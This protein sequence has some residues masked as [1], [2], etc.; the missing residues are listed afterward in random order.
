MR[1]MSF[2]VT[3]VVAASALGAQQQA[4]VFRAKT[5]LLQLD[6]TV[7]DKKGVPVRGLTKDDFTLLEDNKPQTIQGFTAVDLPDRKIGGPAWGDRVASDVTSNEIENARIFVLVIDDGLS[8]GVSGPPPGTPDGGAIAL[9]KDGAEA[10]LKSLGPLDLAAVLFTQRTSF[11]QSLTADKAK[12]MAAIRAFPSAGGGDLLPKYMLNPKTGQGLVIVPGTECL[13]RVHALGAMEGLMKVLS[14]LPDRRKAIVYFGGMLP[15][16]H[17]PDTCTVYQRWRDLF[18]LAQQTNVTINPVDTMGLRAGGTVGPW[19]TYGAAAENTG[20]RAVFGSNDLKP[21]LERI[22][23]ENSSYYLLAYS[24]TKGLEDGTFRRLTVKV[25]DR[26][27]VEI[28]A[29]RNYWAPRVRPADEPKPPPPPPEIEAMA[30]ILPKADLKLRATAAAFAGPGPERAVVAI[31]LGIKQPPLLARTPENV[32][33]ILKA[34]SANGDASGSDTQMIP[35]TVPAARAD[36]ELSRYEILARME[37][38]RPGRYE[39]RLSAK[40]SISGT[41][42]AVYVDVDVPD[43]SRARLSLSGLVLNA[44]PAPGPVAPAR[45]LAD[46]TPLAP[47]SERTFAPADLVTAFVRVYQGGNDALAPV[48]MKVRIA[49]EADRA[50]HEKSETLAPERFGPARAAEYQVRLPLAELKPGRY[51]FALQVSVGKTTASRE[52][53]F[54]VR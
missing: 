53:A 50:V 42:G 48:T 2:M 14:S 4:P 12:L 23:I 26:P 19:A 18:A 5:E 13:G 31:A 52:T 43:F 15:W 45:G 35:I 27:D 25:K 22:R 47:T 39:L 7:L 17:E 36:A 32:E 11:S 44:L 3:L 49:D 41:T 21:G 38:P 16:A 20:G 30:G 6:V 29:R 40:S 1:F 9:M 8:M 10:F 28:V 54:S 34:F 37:L 46:V 51:L 24:P 33:I